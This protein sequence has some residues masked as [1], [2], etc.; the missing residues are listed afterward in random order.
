MAGAEAAGLRG[1]GGSRGREER[2]TRRAGRD[3]AAATAAAGVAGV[4]GGAAE[5][6]GEGVA[7]W[8]GT[9][10]ARVE[11]ASVWCMLCHTLGVHDD[12]LVD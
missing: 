6:S 5:G 7:H 9:L 12:Q 2:V 4:I 3:L 1:M 11:G 8:S 10:E